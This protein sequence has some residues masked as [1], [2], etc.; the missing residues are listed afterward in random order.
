LPVV[1]RTLKRETH[2]AGGQQVVMNAQETARLCAIL[3]PHVVVPMHYTFTG[4]PILDKL[5]LKY[6]GTPEELTQRFQQATAR[7]APETT[8]RILAPGE[9]L[10]VAA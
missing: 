8:V 4:G 6:A 1:G 10:L 9:P 7:L 2:E 3:R 5:V